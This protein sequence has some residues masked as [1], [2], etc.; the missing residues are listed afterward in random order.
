[1]MVQCTK[2]L[3]E[4]LE[5][6]KNALES[7]EGQETFPDNFMAW[8]AHLVTINRRKAVVLMNN[9]SRSPLVIYRPVKKDFKNIKPLLKQAMKEAFLM[10]GYREDLIEAY[11][12]KAGEIGFSKT[13]SRALV[14]R[15]NKAVEEIR[16]F[17]E[18]LN[19]ETKIQPFISVIT[20]RFIHGDKE[21]RYMEPIEELDACFRKF[22]ETEEVLDIKLYQLH[23]RINLPN[24]EVWRRVLVPSKFTAKQLHHVVQ[25]AFDWQNYHLHEFTVD[26]SE[27]K[28]LKI[29]MDGSPDLLDLFDFETF[30]MTKE[31]FVD[32]ETIF[33]ENAE[34]LYEYDF[35]DGW[36][37][38]ITWEKIVQGSELQAMYV[39]GVG[40]RPPEDVGGIPGYEEYAEI[41][42]NENHPEHESMKAWA[43]EQRE[44]AISPEKINERMQDVIM[45]YST[46]II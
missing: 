45:N 14:A 21:G 46:L 36:E 24:H 13:G 26:K 40:E 7:A 41:M 44:R 4:K 23:V 16:F 18:Y 19:P 22:Y 25:T 12:E 1:M 28:P 30:D 43:E 11:L 38:I 10:E 2:A 39:D 35:G 27:Q 34:I 42:Q 31:Q 15:L 29:V 5:I 17:E 20:N 32:L 33:Q 3:L 37:H 8:Q 6:S 9:A